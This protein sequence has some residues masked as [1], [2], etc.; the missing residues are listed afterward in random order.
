LQGYDTSLIGSLFAYNIFAKK[1]GGELVDGKYTL[2]SAW[3]TGL[4]NGSSVGSLIGLALN[5]IIADRLGYKKTMI[6]ALLFM[7]AVTF[8]PFF[9]PNIIVLEVGQC[10]CGIPW[11]IFQTL[12]IAYASEVCPTALRHYLTSYANICWVIGQIIASGVLRGML[13]NQTEWGYR[14]PFA[15][16]WLWPL[17]ICVGV[18]FAPESP[19]WLVRHNRFDEAM[20]SVRRLQRKSEGEESVAATVSMIRLTNEQEKAIS[21]GTSYLDCFKSIDLRR[22][23]VACVTWICQNMC[24]SALMGYR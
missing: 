9:A 17:P 14:I 22:T 16:Q 11:G 15:L 12:A 24:G 4:Q 19:Y 8:I 6:I 18:I 23:E 20:N 1:Y 5:G 7:T 10:L 3:Q 13:S 2:S 21:E